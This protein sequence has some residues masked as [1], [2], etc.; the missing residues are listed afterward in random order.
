MKMNET[1]YAICLALMVA[2]TSY[3]W[4]EDI[5]LFLGNPAEESD[6]LPNVLIL[7]DNTANWN[8]AF[9]NE[10]AAL[11]TTFNGLPLDKFNVGLMTFGD[12]AVG[13]IRAAIRPM[14]ATNRPLYSALVGS[15]DQSGDRANARTLARNISEAY[16][17]LKG[18]ESVDGSKVKSS[19]NSNRDYAGN[20]SGTAAHDAV[21]ALA[22]NAL[23][24]SNATR[25]NSP[26]ADGSCADTFIIYIG[27]NVSSG[28][29]TKDNNSRNSAAGS[30]LSAAGGDTT[31]I[32]L[33][34]SAHQDNYADE[35]ARFLRTNLGVT[36][37]TVDVD[38]TPRPGGHNNGMG[39][40]DLLESMARQ[41]AG[42]YFR[43]DSSA[44]NGEE[45]VIALNEI[46]SEIQ[47]TNSVF[48]S[49]A[50]P[51][52]TTTQSTFLNQVFIGMF[53]PD[54]GAKPRWYGNLKQYRLGLVGSGANE[55]LKLLDARGDGEEA[56]NSQTGFI[57]E[58]ARSYWTPLTADGYWASPLVP[59]G[60]C[61]TGVP[62]SNSPDGPV[63][64]K[65][66]Q[67]YMMRLDSSVR[68]IYSCDAAQG[69]NCA[70]A[71]GALA[72]HG[73]ADADNGDALTNWSVGQDVDNE[74]QRATTMRASLHGDVIH[75][76]PVALNYGTDASPNVVVFYGAN[77][78]I[79]RAINGN[80]STASGAIPAGAEHWAFK[81]MEFGNGEFGRLRSNDP[82]IKFPATSTPAGP[83]GTLKDY[84][85]DGSVVAF[86]GTF[87]GENKKF[88]YATLRRG[89]RSVYAFDVTSIGSPSLLWRVGC[90][91]NL[92]TSNACT[93]SDWENIGQTW[94][95]PSLTY[96]SG[97]DDGEADPS[98]VPV[99][100]M[101]GGYDTCDDYDNNGNPNPQNSSCTNADKG[102]S[103][104]VMDGA[105]GAVLREFSTDYAV[106]GAVTVVPVAEGDNRI[107]FAYAA[108][109]GG[110]VYR[111]SG[112]LVD[113]AP[114]EV[115]SAAPAD[116]LITKIAALGC[117][118]TSPCPA[119][120]K[121]LFGPDV[122]QLEGGDGKLFI[123]IGSG[124]REKPVLNYGAA[125]AVSNYAFALVDNP[126]EAGWLT[127]NG[128][129][130]ANLICLDR[131][132]SVTVAS[133][134]PSGETLS[135]F[136]WRMALD[137]TEQVVSS[138]LTLAGSV[139]FST[140]IPKP[141]DAGSCEAD[142]GIA[143]T[144][145]VDLQ[146]GEGEKINIVGGGLVPSPVAGRVI[147]DDGTIVPF[148]IGCGGEESA[149]GSKQIN[150]GANW[151]Q[152][153][154]RVYWKIQP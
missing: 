4:A 99:I 94:S 9:N 64:E 71:A 24:G 77:D 102:N 52:S 25:Y 98:L 81:P 122:V 93:H 137:P 53:R 144:Y 44:N 145:N 135:N 30:E 150:V 15:L 148:C 47:A 58:C 21:H 41:S 33:Q 19:N 92:E 109:T 20:T 131:L 136:G 147:L 87:G 72:V 104:Y 139:A 128:T 29:V 65:G 66:G 54:A 149:I 101:G 28:N 3:G 120:R 12:P 17:Y 75:S 89:G 36:I 35:W 110:N 107:K 90:E 106:P 2:W 73:T 141:P 16:R 51:A 152:P 69:V 88:L 134:L 132:T 18:M 39:N 42:K 11:V 63:V 126:T 79:L 22:G 143:T 119:R 55:A 6:N 113:G 97:Y 37:Y 129:C 105:S 95:P 26:L 146:T 31:Q 49:V 13:Q 34:Y 45:I 112:P 86:D 14:N 48:A 115:G 85:M 50:L 140:H 114:S 27:N 108:D 23:S 59:R 1:L 80:R 151:V 46:F 103:I 74:D 153:K 91:E 83:Q 7:L 8:T 68:T 62:Q 43:V 40:S 76:R 57:T 61:Q 38:P 142:L 32:Q 78:G 118:S 125:A 117:D 124:D 67:A 154:G 121:F 84:G 96:I 10:K 130:S 56:I 70:N 82:V 5:D 60:E 138:A 100:L 111:I 116:W 123:L 127:D 133:G